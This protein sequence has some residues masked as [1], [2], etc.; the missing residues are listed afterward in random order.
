[1]FL[2]FKPK[3]ILNLFLSTKS[4]TSL[5]NQRNILKSSSLLP[6]KAKQEWNKTTNIDHSKAN[7]KSVF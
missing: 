1:M 7:L 5:E 4:V 3:T 2:T 6:H